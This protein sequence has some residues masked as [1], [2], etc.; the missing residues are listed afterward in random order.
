M[1]ALRHLPTLLNVDVDVDVDLARSWRV[2]G[3]NPIWDSHF[4]EFVFLCAFPI[5]KI[6]KLLASPPPTNR[7]SINEEGCWCSDSE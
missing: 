5:S 2:V 1:I 4:S 7:G 3:S 6:P